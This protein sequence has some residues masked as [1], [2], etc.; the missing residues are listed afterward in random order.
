MFRLFN[1]RREDVIPIV[2]HEGFPAFHHSLPEQAL[3]VLLTSTLSSTYYVDAER[4]TGEISMVLK[5]A[6]QHH[7]ELLAR[8]VVYARETGCLRLLPTLGTAYLSTTRPDL[9]ARVFPRV[10]TTPRE[11][12]DLVS[13]CRRGAVRK[14]LGRS[15]KRAMGRFLLDLSPYHFIKYGRT[16]R[17]VLRLVRPRPETPE[18][19]LMLR[20]L[21]RGI[22]AASVEE[23]AGPFPQLAAW[24]RFLATGEL[25]L[26]E[27]GRLPYEAVVGARRPTLQMWHLL[28]RQLPQL[29]LLRHLAMLERNFILDDKETRAY[30][31]ARFSDREAVRR[32]RVLPF[33]YYTAWSAWRANWCTDVKDA[34]A[35]GLEASL[36]NLPDLSGRICLAVD[37]S[38]S[39]E[40]PVTER[41]RIRLVDVAALLAAALARK[42]PE[43]TRVIPFNH[44][45]HPFELRPQESVFSTL[46]RL[47]QMCRGGTD[48]AAPFRVLDEPVDHYIGITDNMDWAGWGFLPAWRRYR[49]AHPQAQ[50]YL[51]TLAP[52][53]ELPAPENE[54]GVH[55]LY[56]WGESVVAHLALC[57]S[58]GTQLDALPEL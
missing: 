27:E 11:L 17:P 48:L 54:P 26:I 45:P 28:C 49:E 15:V 18:Q 3:Q 7:P 40:M 51:L 46:R 52:Y 9:F 34:L 33:R 20:I 58:G 31:C 36:G 32:S 12:C 25:A 37:I 56:G 57:A 22:K 39:M 23:L 2:N 5:A 1:E 53:P 55:F 19:A 43:R 50:A 13:M 42:A 21:S 41:S 6:S 16:L 4:I 29:A 47:A 24:K 10:V 38:G 14:G 35:A 8:S 44:L 30:V